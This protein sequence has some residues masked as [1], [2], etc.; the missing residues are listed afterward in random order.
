MT[1]FESII[2]HAMLVLG[3]AAFFEIIMVSGLTKLSQTCHAYRHLQLRKDAVIGAIVGSTT[4]RL[5]F[6]CRL[7]LFG[8]MPRAIVHSS[9]TSIRLI[10]VARDYERNLIPNRR[11]VFP[12]F[13][14]YT[15]YC[16]VC[17]SSHPGRRRRVWRE[18]AAILCEMLHEGRDV[19]SEPWGEESFRK[20]RLS[21]R[22]YRRYYALQ[23]QQHHV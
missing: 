18:I 23:K 7:A 6:E 8:M 1:E 19:G 5:H 22:H 12:T 21:A 4:A 9:R 10:R 13:Y 20:R 14:A 17:G 3:E 16:G 15:Y 2:S 11:F